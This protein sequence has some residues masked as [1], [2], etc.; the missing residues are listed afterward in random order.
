MNDIYE[1]I[2]KQGYDDG[3]CKGLD[4]AWECA[5]KIIKIWY[6]RF[7]QDPNAFN[8]FFKLNGELGDDIF[9][10]FFQKYSA[11]EAIEKLEQYE[12]QKKSV[13]WAEL[14]VGDV[15]IDKDDIDNNR[16]TEY[17][18]TYVYQNSAEFDAITTDGMV[19]TE[20]QTVD[21]VKIDKRYE[22]H[23]KIKG[24]SDD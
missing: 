21:M 8:D 1:K 17:I 5:R 11:S 7:H 13:L 9:D 4:D 2:Y 22:I 14:R 18:V 15:L 6:S 3:H 19:Y 12:K 20:M 24:E 10:L 16:R 23:F